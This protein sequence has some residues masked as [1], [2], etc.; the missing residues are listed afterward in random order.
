MKQGRAF[1]NLSQNSQAD[2]LRDIGK[3]M[4]PYLGVETSVTPDGPDVL[5]GGD[6]LQG[7]GVDTLA[8]VVN[9]WK[10]RKVT[11]LMAPKGD[12]DGGGWQRL[13]N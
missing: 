13:T 9:R 12:I 6:A 11:S 8:T 5:D 10:I 3:S 1:K 2:N 7:R 4:G